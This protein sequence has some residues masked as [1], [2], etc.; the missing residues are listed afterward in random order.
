MLKQT[1]ANITFGLRGWAFDTFGLQKMLDRREMNQ[2]EDHMG[3]RGQIPEH[4][5]FQLDFLKSQGLKPQNTLMEVG[6]GPMT[7][8][9][10]LIEYLEPGNYVGIDVRPEVLNLSWQQIGKAGLSAKNPRLIISSTFG[11]ESLGDRAFDFILTF[12]VL[13]HLSDDILDRWLAMVARRGAVAY[14]NINN[15]MDS[16][17]WLQ[18]PF[19]NRTVET[20][21]AMAAQHGLRTEDLGTIEALGFKLSGA[22][23]LNPLLRFSR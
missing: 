19:L 14:A 20:Y 7:A 23:R 11:T 8:G 21:R 13:Y 4:R 16:S 18:F 17:T 22:E 6:C 2:L 12:S 9:V 15:T 10:P 3:F 1:R 5:R